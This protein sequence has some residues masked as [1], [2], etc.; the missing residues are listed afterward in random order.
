MRHLIKWQLEL[1][2][3]SPLFYR[4]YMEHEKWARE[5]GPVLQNYFLSGAIFQEAT[6]IRWLKAV[7]LEWC[8]N[9]L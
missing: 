6:E 3:E 8:K 5:I 7:V 2:I 1:C 9:I 4:C